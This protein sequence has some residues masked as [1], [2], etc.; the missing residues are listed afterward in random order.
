MGTPL[1]GKSP[2]TNRIQGRLGA[3]TIVPLQTSL[4]S[5]LNPKSINLK[6]LS[7]VTSGDA[8]GRKLPKKSAEVD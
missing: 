2:Q 5:G 3:A 7:S 8:A 1:P 6:S 4:K